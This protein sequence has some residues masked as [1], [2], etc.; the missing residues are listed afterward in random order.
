MFNQAL[1]D[2]VAAAGKDDALIFAEEAERRA[3]S[4]TD[5]PDS[6]KV[7]LVDDEPE[8]HNITKLALEDFTYAQKPLTFISAYSGREAQ[9]LIQTHDDVALML[10]D[11]VMETEHAGLD[12]VKFIRNTLGNQ[13]V[14]IVLRTG[15]PGQAPEDKVIIAY[16]INDYKTKTEL[17]FEKLFTTVVTALRAFDLVTKLEFQRRENSRQN[18]EL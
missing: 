13:L 10:L 3:P 9:V 1:D 12:L 2:A 18:V 14:R 15:Q 11:V 6:W 16:D 8:I 4:A 7:M 17:T 5:Q